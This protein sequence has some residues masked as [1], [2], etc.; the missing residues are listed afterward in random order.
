MT[1][2]VGTN[3]NNLSAST[4]REPI[5]LAAKRPPMYSNGR[6]GERASEWSAG[7]R[8][9]ARPR[10]DW[11]QRWGPSEQVA[12]LIG[13][14]PADCGRESLRFL[15]SLGSRPKSVLCR[16]AL[17]CIREASA[18]KRS[19]W[20]LRERGPNGRTAGL[21]WPQFRAAAAAAACRLRPR[22][23]SREQRAASSEQRPETR[24]PRLGTRDSGAERR[25]SWGQREC[26]AFAPPN[27]LALGALSG[28]QQRTHKA[29]A[30]VQSAKAARQ[31]EARGRQGE[32]AG[33]LFAGAERLTRLAAL[34]RISRLGRRAE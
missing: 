31:G 12:R 21:R 27:R 19:A 1:L 18:A 7:R 23:E 13:P 16:A 9:Q 6:L 26:R 5:E 10:T 8:W 32:R 3:A 33:S 29:R 2:P 20:R 4:E 24:D 28:A 15:N 11:A 30:R 22:P 17:V 34:T 25:S 14:H